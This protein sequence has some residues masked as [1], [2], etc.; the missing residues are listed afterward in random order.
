MKLFVVTAFFFSSLALSVVPAQSTNPATT[1]AEEASGKQDKKDQKAKTKS[2][3]EAPKT[4][5]GDAAKKPSSSQDAAYAAAYK[6]GIP[7]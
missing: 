7:K 3:K 2:Q 5:N 6:A 1:H 4:T